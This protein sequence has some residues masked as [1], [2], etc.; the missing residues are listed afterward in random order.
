M[1]SGKRIYRDYNN[2]ATVTWSLIW[3][4]SSVLWL[5]FL[6]IWSICLWIHFHVRNSVGVFVRQ[7]PNLRQERAYVKKKRYN[8]KMK[9]K[10]GTRNLNARIVRSIWTIQRCMITKLFLLFGKLLDSWRLNDCWFIQSLW[11]TGRSAPFWVNSNRTCYYRKWSTTDA[12]YS[13]LDYFY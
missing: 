3:K 5:S 11:T 12:L 4:H 7:D 2:T 1:A 10:K 6:H 8:K 13:Y 9:R